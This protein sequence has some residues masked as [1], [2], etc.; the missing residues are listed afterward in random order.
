VTEILSEMITSLGYTVD[1]ARNG[2]AGIERYRSSQGSIDLILLD[3]NMPVMDGHEA[4]DEIR[5]INPHANIIIVTGYGRKSAETSSF[6]G[7]VQAIIQKPFQ[8][9]TLALTLRQVLDQRALTS[10]HP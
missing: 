1:I 6:S 9:E 4:F 2:K 10:A 5:R 3:V 8:I 7:P